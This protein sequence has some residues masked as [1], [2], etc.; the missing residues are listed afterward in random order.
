MWQCREW[1]TEKTQSHYNWYAQR[2]KRKY[3]SHE[4][5]KV[6]FWKEPFKKLQKRRD[7]GN[8]KNDIRN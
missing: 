1:E 4:T 7:F 3:Y 6:S 8:L 5:Q 2:T